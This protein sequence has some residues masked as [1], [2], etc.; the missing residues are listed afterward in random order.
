MY[1]KQEHR[2]SV[3]A[4]EIAVWKQCRQKWYWQYLLRIEPAVTHTK[5]AQGTMAH[6]GIAA[7]LSG[8]SVEIAV[9]KSAMDLSRS[10]LLSVDGEQIDTTQ[11]DDEINTISA[12]V[13]KWN[14][15]SGIREGALIASEVEWE[16]PVRAGRRRLPGVTWNGR[17][18]ALIAVGESGEKWGLEAKYVGR[19]R[20][21][22]SVELSSQLAMY[23]LFMQEQKVGISQPPRLIY[24]QILNKMPAVP[25]VNKT[26]SIS[27]SQTNTDW[28]TYREAVVA[29]G[30]NPEDYSDMR[31][32][33]AGKRFWAEQVV[34]RSENRLAEEREALYDVTA[35]IMQ[36]RKR[37]YMCDSPFLCQ[38]C[39]FRDM[40]LETVRGRD[41]M[42]LVESGAFVSRDRPV[43]DAE[44]AS[45][46]S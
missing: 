4:S 31:E 46:E 18:D 43:E 37:I 25:S 44:A 24:L 11:A 3:S 17:M 40:C 12:C 1:L 16:V 35:E 34:T 30:Y 13:K 36:K 29:N 21:E 8:E 27:R 9:T 32:K 39:Q 6:A 15:E 45:D 33:L 28:D 41:P 2:P 22:E 20:S 7:A 5:L 23:L 42:E 38:S 19:F 26:G 14:R 10:L